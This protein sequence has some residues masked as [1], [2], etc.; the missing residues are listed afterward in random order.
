VFNE[1]SVPC[2][3]YC[4]SKVSFPKLAL[5]LEDTLLDA[6]VMQQECTLRQQKDPKNSLKIMG[7]YGFKANKSKNCW[8]EMFT[9]VPGLAEAARKYSPSNKLT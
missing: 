9:V 1:K 4:L 7:L 3:E 5:G 6:V 2:S 8:K